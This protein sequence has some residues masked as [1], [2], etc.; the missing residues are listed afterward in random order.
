MKLNVVNIKNENTSE[1]TLHNGFAEA[2]V[3]TEALGH[4]LRAYLFNQRQGTASAKNRGEVAGSGIKPW[5]Q[6]GT[7]RA[8]V[9]D[10]RTPLWR[11]GGIVHAPKPKSWNLGL[12]SNTKKVALLSALS[13]K[14]NKEAVTVIESFADF[15]T[16]TKD[17][18]K[19]LQKLNLTRNVLLVVDKLSDETGR[20][21][22]NIKGIKSSLVDNLNAFEVFS[23]DK[24]LISKEALESLEKKMFKN[25]DK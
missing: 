18:F 19:H 13:D 14:F 6:K 10:K 11:H 12:N 16:K 3:N 25:E 4:Y 2:R 15:N 20:G 21:L 8:R 7:G 22:Q 5:R 23:A 9:G 17:N 1:K 24:I